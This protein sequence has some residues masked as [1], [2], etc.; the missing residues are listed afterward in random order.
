MDPIDGL[1]SGQYRDVLE[2][3]T[4]YV[5][6]AFSEADSQLNSEKLWPADVLGSQTDINFLGW[7]FHFRDFFGDVRLKEIEMPNPRCGYVGETGRLELS[8]EDVGA[9]LS[10]M[11]SKKFRISYPFVVETRGYGCDPKESGVQDSYVFGH[12][13]R[14]T[15][16]DSEDDFTITPSRDGL[17]L[18]FF[19]LDPTPEQAAELLTVLAAKPQYGSP[20][21]HAAVRLGHYL[22]QA[23]LGAYVTVEA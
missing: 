12:S 21:V 18:A 17:R 3:M 20:L 8:Q 22:K 15:R 7:L 16:T 4:G 6:T 1:S 2:D 14:R 5:E 9:I 23:S 19:G 13:W 10:L 11:D